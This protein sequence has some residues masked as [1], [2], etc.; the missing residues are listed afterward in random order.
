MS[1]RRSANRHNV[2]I[3]VCAEYPDLVAGLPK[4][5]F[6]SENH[7]RSFVTTGAARDSEG[8]AII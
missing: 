7:F 8:D 1:F 3:E 5:I 6:Q 2:W 4:W